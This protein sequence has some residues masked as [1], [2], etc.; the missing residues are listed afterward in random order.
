MAYVH[1]DRPSRRNSSVALDERGMVVDM[2][3]SFDTR[4][5]ER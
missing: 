2:A 5:E 3:A 4:E 1:L